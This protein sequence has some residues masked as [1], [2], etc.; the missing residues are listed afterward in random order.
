MYK[1]ATYRLIAVSTPKGC[2][3]RVEK[4]VNEESPEPGKGVGTFSFWGGIAS[5]YAQKVKW[6]YNGR[7]RG[8]P[9]LRKRAIS[10]KSTPLGRF[11]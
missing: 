4:K 3:A 7:V 9:W 6:M 10:A 11:R 2:F 8:S 5:P 1:A